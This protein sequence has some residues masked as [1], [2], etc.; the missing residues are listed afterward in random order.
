[1]SVEAGLA[2]HEGWSPVRAVRDPSNLLGFALA[3]V[4][5][6]AGGWTLPE[7]CW[8]I[9]LAGLSL[10]WIRTVS[11]AAEIVLTH[12]SRRAE[13][14]RHLA[15]VRSMPAAAY[16]AALVLLVG[17]LALIVLYA[18]GFAFGLYGLLLS[19]FAEMEPLE[20][21]GRNGFI[22]ADF[23]TSVTY[24]TVAFWP[25]AVGT[26]VANW[27][28]LFGGDPWKRMLVP[29]EATVLRT[30]L[31]VVLMPFIALLAWAL[32]GDA[33]HSVTIVLLMALFY[34]V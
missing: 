2:K 16:A 13:Y 18:Y 12:R 15:V 10:A 11:G 1:M 32:V 14:D 33:Y 20:L 8:S 26:L 6:V 23:S 19:F 5:A 34:L 17:S 24:L 28:V 30:H 31:L 25:M 21:F 9:W 7:F 27:T 29:A 22:N 3:S 4:F